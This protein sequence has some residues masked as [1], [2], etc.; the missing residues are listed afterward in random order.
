MRSLTDI[1]KLLIKILWLLVMN[2]HSTWLEM[3]LQAAKL[4]KGQGQITEGE[5]EILRR[6]SASIR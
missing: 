1:S 6:A 4:I 3:E 5:R 2:W